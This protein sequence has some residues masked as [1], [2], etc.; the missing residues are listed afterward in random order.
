M[1]KEKM[2]KMMKESVRDRLDI[3]DDAEWNAIQPK[4]SA[5]IDARAATMANMRNAFGGGRRGG[6][7]G[8]NQ[9]QQPA[10]PGL[11]TPGPAM[12]ALQKAVDAKATPAQLKPLLANYRAEV[13]ANEDK[14]AKAQDDLKSVLTP[15]QEATALLMG[16]VR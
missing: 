3:T 13:K 14:L 5:V 11:A 12:D 7:G 6:Q 2:S 4:V 10:R 9:G 15:Q 16:L 8:G 1:E